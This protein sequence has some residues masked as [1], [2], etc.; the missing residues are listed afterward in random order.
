[1]FEIAT[2][3]ITIVCR[4]S[5]LNLT[6]ILSEKTS[7]VSQKAGQLH[8]SQVSLI[9]QARLSRAEDFLIEWGCKVGI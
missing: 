8:L 3:T 5:E 6:S 2:V 7:I 9:S 4:S 1:V